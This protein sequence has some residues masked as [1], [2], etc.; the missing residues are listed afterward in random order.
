MKKTVIN[1][2][3]TLETVPYDHLLPLVKALLVRNK[4]APESIGFYCDRDGWR[5]DLDFPIDFEYI[6]E[7][8]VIPES[9]LLSLEHRSILCLKTWCVITG[10]GVVPIVNNNNPQANQ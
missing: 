9:I 8:F 4:R 10:M 2:V 1:S 3:P 7:H 6:R 5:C